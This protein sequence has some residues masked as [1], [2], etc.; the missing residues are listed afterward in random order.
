MTG[1]TKRGNNAAAS[2][3]RRRSQVIRLEATLDITMLES[4]HGQWCKALDA[5]RP[6]VVDGGRVQHIDGA[7]LQL[8]CALWREAPRRDAD[9]RWRNVSPVISDAAGLAGLT[10]ELGLSSGPAGPT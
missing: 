6:I 10:R 7:A 4:L 2:G 9:L 5:G 1:T 8:L 3:K